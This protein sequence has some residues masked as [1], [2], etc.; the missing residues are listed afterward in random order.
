[1]A[2]HHP[3]RRHGATRRSPPPQ[4]GGGGWLVGA[5]LFGTVG[6]IGTLALSEDGRAAITARVKPVA[7][8]MGLMW[9]RT[10][11]AGDHW[12]GCDPVR[13]AGSAPLYRGEPGYRED[14]DGDGDGVA[15]EP[16]Q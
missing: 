7:V 9:A 14:M 2:R 15:C 12:R 3:T 1:M 16:I 5:A 4:R 6:G 11:R 10:P 13:A 8:T